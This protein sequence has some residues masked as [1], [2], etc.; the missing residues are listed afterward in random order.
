MH[1]HLPA[2]HIFTACTPPSLQTEWKR[3]IFVGE[4][5]AHPSLTGGKVHQPKGSWGNPEKLSWRKYQP[6]Q[7]AGSA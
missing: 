3:P 1:L 4:A 7:P 6:W 5:L 2:L